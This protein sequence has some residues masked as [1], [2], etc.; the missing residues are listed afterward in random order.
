MCA[1]WLRNVS[2][3][4]VRRAWI[5]ELLS[6][7][8]NISVC[9]TVAVLNSSHKQTSHWVNE[10][11]RSTPVSLF[12]SCLKSPFHHGNAAA[13][14]FSGSPI[15]S[16]DVLWKAL[17]ALLALFEPPQLGTKQKTLLRQAEDE[18]ARDWGDP[19]GWCFCYHRDSL[20]PEGTK[21]ALSSLRARGAQ[22]A[23]PVHYAAG[24]D[25]RDMN[26]GPT[27]GF[28][29]RTPTD[30]VPSERFVWNSCHMAGAYWGLVQ[31][32]EEKQ[33]K[34]WKE[35][36]ESNFSNFEAPIIELKTKKWDWLKIQSEAEQST[37]RPSRQKG[38][39]NQVAWK[40]AIIL[41][42]WI[43]C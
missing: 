34:S 6:T 42:I 2:L 37:P 5:Q 23:L 9:T 1:Y 41:A 22:C 36:D 21:S 17:S 24:D 19:M 25:I 12:L 15:H 30:K 28:L 13:Q 29:E 7:V 16:R 10:A 4:V 40:V 31:F 33:T 26:Q 32:Q 11:Q 27:A 14:L 43:R 18:N 20:T 35:A 8:I 3:T 39:S 38:K